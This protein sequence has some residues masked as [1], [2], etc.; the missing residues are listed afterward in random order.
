MIYA[1]SDFLF[2]FHCHRDDI[3]GD[4]DKYLLTNSSLKTNVLLIV[5]EFDT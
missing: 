3:N 1:L 4:I 5:Q 2:T